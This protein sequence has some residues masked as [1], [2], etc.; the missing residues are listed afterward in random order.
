MFNDDSDRQ[1]CYTLTAFESSRKCVYAFRF[2]NF[3]RLFPSLGKRLG[4]QLLN[5][6]ISKLV[7]SEGLLASSEV[8]FV[9]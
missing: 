9:Y 5:H 6:W 8:K 1:A 3:L 4:T 7:G 2:A